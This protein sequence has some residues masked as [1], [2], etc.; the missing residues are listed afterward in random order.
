[1]PT[2]PDPPI[3]A[4]PLGVVTPGPHGPGVAPAGTVA[5]MTVSETTV[6]G[7]GTTGKLQ[8]RM[9]RLAPVRWVPVMVTVVPTGPLVGLIPEIVGGGFGGSGTAGST[10]RVA[11]TV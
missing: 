4:V 1:M 6:N 8:E 9:T 3:A 7:A 5:L 2:P 10:T 11:A